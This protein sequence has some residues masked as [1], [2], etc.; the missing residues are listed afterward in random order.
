[1]HSDERADR[2]AFIVAAGTGNGNDL[3]GV[4]LLVEDDAGIFRSKQIYTTANTCEYIE[5]LPI[6][7][8]SATGGIYFNNM[9]VCTNNGKCYQLSRD[10][11]WSESLEWANSNVDV[12]ITSAIFNSSGNSTWMFFPET[13]DISIYPQLP[14]NSALN[15]PAPS[16]FPSV[17]MIN[18]SAMF[19]SFSSRK[20]WIYNIV[21]N[22]LIPLPDT[23]E[24]R[25]GAACGVINDGNEVVLAGGY[26]KS[27]Y[28]M[29]N[30]SVP[31]PAWRFGLE[32][33]GYEP[34]GARI[35]PV[36]NNQRL[37][38]V[39][40]ASSDQAVTT[41]KSFSGTTY[42]WTEVGDLNTARFNAAAFSV[43]LRSLSAV[44][45]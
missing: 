36:D 34:F 21:T 19:V 45:S 30:L 13:G 9:H 31:N 25:L 4:E 3:A 32:D 42:R 26:Q 23:K 20:A 5:D 15:L 12:P 16:D 24:S 35:V 41:I 44:C 17:A 40:G 11:E 22:T 18:D 33:L 10:G 6:A 14:S 38:L 1:M 2:T 39:G 27:T 8:Q 43:S 29:I 28:E 7:S 37:L